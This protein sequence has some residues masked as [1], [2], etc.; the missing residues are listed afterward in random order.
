M[1]SLCLLAR[2]SPAFNVFCSQPQVAT[3]VKGME[4]YEFST[5]TSVSGLHILACLW[6]GFLVGL[7][8]RHLGERPG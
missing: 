4:A 3:I 8:H 2:S 7:L 6:L 5:A 1:P